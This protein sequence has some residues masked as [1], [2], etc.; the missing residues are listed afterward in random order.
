MYLGIELRS[1][2]LPLGVRGASVEFRDG[3]Q[4]FDHGTPSSIATCA[5]PHTE[6]PNG[7]RLLRGFSVG[8]FL[9]ACACSDGSER[10][11]VPSRAAQLGALSSEPAD[12]VFD[13]PFAIDDD[14]EAILAVPVLASTDRSGRLLAADKSDKNIKIYAPSGRR[15]G[16]IGR[17]GGGPGEFMSLMGA[18]SYRD[19]IAA[20]DFASGRLTVFTLAGDPVRMLTPQPQ[21]FDIRVVDDSLFLL[22]H[23]PG[24]GGNML[25]LVRPDG[26]QMSQF[27]G[28]QL[29][30]DP[31]LR[32]HS[33]V[34]ADAHDGVVFAGVFGQD[35]IFAFDYQG[36]RLAASPT[37]ASTPVGSFEV[38]LEANDG[39]LRREPDGA[40]FQDGIYALV[41]LVALDGARAALFLARYDTKVG[42]DL[43]QGGELLVVGL[44]EGQ[45]VPLGGQQVS[46][47]LMGRDR[48]NALLLIGYGDPQGESITVQRLN[49]R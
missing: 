48:K 5:G 22:I 36:R 12:L 49:V 4:Q 37:Q 28:S 18:Q 24:Q 35:S 27:F 19:S 9:F 7:R 2:S 40:W 1:E 8:L 34:F 6:V 26:T 46:A 14:R 13:A 39:A 11:H 25:R 47:G 20:Y 45:L 3:G 41:K 21:P 38:M 30:E 44:R 29:F 17:P 23:H 10:E 16:T 33:A 32:H 31:R 43:L 15:V 42:T